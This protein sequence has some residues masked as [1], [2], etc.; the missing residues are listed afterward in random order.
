MTL[1][2][3]MTMIQKEAAAMEKAQTQ[4]M[5]KVKTPVVTIVLTLRELAQDLTVREMA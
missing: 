4:E 5:G 3:T 2:L 1:I